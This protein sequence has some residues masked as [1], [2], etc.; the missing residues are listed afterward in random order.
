[1][2]VIIV[3][4]GY[5][6]A[7]SQ[8]QGMVHGRGTGNHPSEKWIFGIITPFLQIHEFQS[9]IVNLTHQLGCVIGAS[10]THND[11]LD[12]PICLIQQR[13]HGPVDQ[14]STAIVRGDADRD[15]RIWLVICGLVACIE[16]RL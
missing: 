4:V 9:R 8:R 15:E 2:F 11:Y 3:E 14:Q 13:F 5:E 7:A 1:V 16:L 12:V 10:I 6:V